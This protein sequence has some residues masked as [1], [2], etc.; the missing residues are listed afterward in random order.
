MRWILWSGREKEKQH[1]NALALALA[2][3]LESQKDALIALAGEVE[4]S[5][6][7]MKVLK[8][9]ESAI[10]KQLGLDQKLNQTSMFDQK[11]LKK[12]A[13]DIVNE[14]ISTLKA[15]AQN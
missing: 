14:V 8:A 6:A 7:I 15:S 2:P 12:M 4:K 13:S 3:I 10:H 1:I 5:P 9:A 11:S